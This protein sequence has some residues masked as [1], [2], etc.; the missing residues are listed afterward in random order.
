MKTTKEKNYPMYAAGR[1]WTIPSITLTELPDAAFTAVNHLLCYLIQHDLHVVVDPQYRHDV[2]V[3]RQWFEWSHVV[4]TSDHQK[5]AIVGFTAIAV[6]MKGDDETPIGRRC[7][8]LGV[9]VRDWTDRLE[10][11]IIEIDTHQRRVTTH[12]NANRQHVVK[13]NK[14]KPSAKQMLISLGIN[15]E[16]GDLELHP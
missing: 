7:E 1:L 3:M 9:V 12:L 6:P 16:L 2:L 4:V 14:D 5:L 10:R 15:D 13:L 11:A 8:R